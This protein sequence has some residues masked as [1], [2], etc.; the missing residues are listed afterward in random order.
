MKQLNY[1]VETDTDTHE[2]PINHSG[3]EKAIKLANENRTN[4]EVKQENKGIIS[5]VEIWNFTE[6]TCKWADDIGRDKV[7]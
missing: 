3:L 4:V 2:F 5:F 1:T 6:E 7:E